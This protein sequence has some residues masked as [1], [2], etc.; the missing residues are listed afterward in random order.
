MNSNMRRMHADYYDTPQK[1]SPEKSVWE[2]IIKADHVKHAAF[3]SFDVN[4]ASSFWP[5]P[6]LDKCSAPLLHPCCDLKEPLR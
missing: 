3:A 4:S 1:G 6:V 5:R 2:H